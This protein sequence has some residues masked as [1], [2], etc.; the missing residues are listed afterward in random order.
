[1]DLHEHNRQAWNRQVDR[2]NRWTLPATPQTIA[3]ARGGD[4]A[5]M[6]TTMRAV[7]RD[8]FP[9]DLKG[10]DLL[11]LAAGG[12]QQ[13]PILA[14]AGARVTVLDA[15]ERQLDQ[16]RLVAER[17]SLEIRTE[18]GDMADLSRFADASFDLVFHPCSNCFVESILPVW[19]E[20][21]RVL[22][23]GGSLLSGF[24]NPL[25]FL[26]DAG[27]PGDKALELRYS[28]PFRETVD[29]PEEKRRAYIERQEPLLS[30]HTLEEQI[31]GQ[32]AAGFLLAGMYED[33]DQDCPLA[34][35]MPIY[36]ATRAIK[37]AD[38]AGARPAG[39]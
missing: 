36:L 13:M 31:G 19:R 11:G 6:L 15:S 18:R 26:F 17:D 38:P 12:G 1:M 39:A 28:L 24:T 34:R 23:P 9:A 16:D 30:S 14:A 20:A 7:P 4:W 32:L 3:D 21:F 35:Y 27:A 2:G 25:V 22:R 5:V 8:W 37:P 29:L 33:S 10:C